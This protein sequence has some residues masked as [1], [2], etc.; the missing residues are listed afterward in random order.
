MYTVSIAFSLFC[1]WE[2]ND[3]G[4]GDIFVME[5]RE[6]FTLD[7]RDYAEGA[8]VVKRPSA[9]GIAVKDGKVLLIHSLKYDYYK[10]ISLP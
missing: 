9:R 5:F 8:K 7:K 1:V 4:Q 2:E 6:L 3:L 10:Y